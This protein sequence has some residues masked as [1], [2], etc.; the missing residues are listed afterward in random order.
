MHIL[1]VI[2]NRTINLGSFTR[3]DEYTLDYFINMLKNGGL[4]HDFS[5]TQILVIRAP[6]LDSIEAVLFSGKEDE[7]AQFYQL[8]K[9]FEEKLK[10]FK[11]FAG[12]FKARMDFLALS[13]EFDSFG[14][15]EN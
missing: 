6:R 8:A 13:D 9:L 4:I 10:D 12:D 14:K 2:G 5:L 11:T 15:N 3:S 1:K 7:M